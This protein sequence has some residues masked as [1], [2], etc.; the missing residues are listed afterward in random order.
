MRNLQKLEKMG[1]AMQNA[2]YFWQKAVGLEEPR[3]WTERSE[4][5]GCHAKYYALA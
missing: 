3:R 5:V 4:V 2:L 1:Y